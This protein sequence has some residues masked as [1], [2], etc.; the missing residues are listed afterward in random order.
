MSLD[1][2]PA[3]P[4][5]RAYADPADLRRR[6]AEVLLPPRRM[7]VSEAAVKYRR[8][9]NPGGGYVGA[10]D[11]AVVPMMVEPMDVLTSRQ[12]GAEIFVGPAQSAKTDA[13]GINWVAHSV[14]CDPAD[15]MMIQTT[16]AEA[17]DFSR[18]RIDRLNRSSPAVGSRLMPTRS[19]NNVYDKTYRGMILTLGHPSISTLSGKPIP[20]VYLTDY[21]RMPE[22]IDGEGAPFALA[23]KRT[24]TFGSAAMTVVESSPGRPALKARWSPSTPHEA[25]PTTGILALYN[26]GTRCRW[27]WPCLDCREWFEGNFASLTWPEGLSATDA[28]AAA[29]MVCP[30]CGCCMASRHKRELNARGLW[31]GEGQTVTVDGDRTG[32]R[33]ASRIASYWLKGPAAVFVGWDE[34]VY[35]YLLAKADFENTGAE[36]SLKTTVNVDQAEPYLPAALQTQ[37]LLDASALANRVEDYPLKSVP[38][39]VLFLTVFIDVQGNRFDVMVRGWGA[40]MESWIVDW[41]QIFRTETADGE[42]RLLD[43]ATHAADW[44]LLFDKV[45]DRGWPLTGAPETEMLAARVCIDS[46][47]G[48]GV[49]EK[50]YKFW[51]KARRK[52]KASRVLLTKG[53]GSLK[54]PRLAVTF[55]DSKRKDRYAGARGEIPVG[56][57]NANLMK[58]EVDAELHLGEPG[59]GYVHFS[60]GLLADDGPPHPFFEQMTAEVRLDTGKWDRKQPRNEA[61]DQMVGTR[62]G[63]LSLKADRINWDRPPVWAMREDGNPLIRRITG[64]DGAAAKTAPGDISALFA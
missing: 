28:A 20:R 16:E 4:P 63:V 62:V 61:W 46:G 45:I 24:Q 12:Y 47:G 33:L 43:P 59:P 56:L 37:N 49:T 57:F 29:E 1:P 10:W 54:A 9:D 21:D 52:G 19:A 64:P 58:D 22:D 36:E 35:R 2:A 34:L 38:P 51:R 55:P 42:E 40:D 60:Q 8:L 39:G 31:V 17:R 30:H 7:R 27:Y 32:E 14:I 25:P 53:E 13:L 6:A 15:M 3:P 5:L 23:Q 41:F 18:R 48:P 26:M 44:D 50:A 11:N